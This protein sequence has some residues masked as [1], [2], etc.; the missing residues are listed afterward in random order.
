MASIRNLKDNGGNVFYPLTHERA[1]K[2]SNGVS[3]ESK[4]AGLESKSYVEAWDGTSTPVEANIPAGVTVTYNTTTYTG[5]LEASASTIGKIYLVKNGS[6]YD[7]YITSQS[8]SSYS[9][10]PI[11][12]TEMDLSDYATEAELTQTEAE[13]GQLE[14]DTASRVTT[15]DNKLNFAHFGYYRWDTQTYVD[16]TTGDKLTDFIEVQEGQKVIVT[17]SPEDPVTNTISAFDANKD[18]VWAN[19]VHGDLTNYEYKVPSGIKYIRFGTRSGAAY[20]EQASVK[21]FSS[22]R[23]AYDLLDSEIFSMR[24]VLTNTLDFSING[25]YRWDTQQFVVSDGNKVTDYL[26]VKPGWDILVNISP[27]D[28]V[29]NT[30]SAF[31]ESLNIIWGDCVHGDLSGYHYIV[32][33]GVKYLRFGTRSGA[34]YLAAASVI[35]P[36]SIQEQDIIN[37]ET[38]KTDNLAN[39]LYIFNGYV[40]SNGSITTGP[41][42]TNAKC[43]RIPIERAGVISFGNYHLDN[44]DSAYYSFHDAEGNVLSSYDLSTNADV[45]V[46]NISI[47]NGAKYLYFTL[48]QNPSTSPSSAYLNVMCNYG[49]SLDE[50]VPYNEFVERINGID[51]EDYNERITEI[52]ENTAICENF[53]DVDDKL[54]YK[55]Q[56]IA[57]ESSVSTLVSD[58][59]VSDG[60][61]IE[62][63][64]AYI[65]SATHVIKVKQ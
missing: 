12:S 59:P 51:V 32:P 9:W 35:F 18:I 22:V 11:G 33:S 49:S 46:E 53:T 4:L 1:V 43:I 6:D 58:L 37:I 38:R 25:Y 44:S 63:G 8:G 65:D 52:E 24:Y 60:T 29:T 57:S 61:G 20:L 64:Y 7:R 30:I 36:D 50:Y 10:S 21:F 26:P 42:Y 14:A 3:L 5:T 41:S 16:D 39:P 47:P 15:I 27:D 23:G 45:K 48:K 13:L 40:S 17:I 55:G 54:Y 62:S 2:D 31:D 56:P 19:C 28:G 34:A